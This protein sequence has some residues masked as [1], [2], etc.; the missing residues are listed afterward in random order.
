MLVPSAKNAVE[1]PGMEES[2]ALIQTIVG[3]NKNAISTLT[4]LLHTPYSSRYYNPTGVTAALLRLDPF[5]DPLRGDL[6]FQKLC[7]EKQD[8][9][10]NP[11]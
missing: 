9:T 6:A 1:G 3:E 2:L 7:E 5:W 10:T 8:P 4:Q 11:H